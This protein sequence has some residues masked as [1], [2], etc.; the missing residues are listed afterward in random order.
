[1]TKLT[2]SKPRGVPCRSAASFAW[3]PTMET[4]AERWQSVSS[5]SK[6]EQARVSPIEKLADLLFM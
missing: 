6:K 3:T 2:H 1:M 4:E 5:P